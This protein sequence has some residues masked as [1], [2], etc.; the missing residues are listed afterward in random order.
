M[1][2]VKYARVLLTKKSWIMTPNGSS[3]HD[4]CIDKAAWKIFAFD[5]PTVIDIKGVIRGEGNWTLR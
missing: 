1:I 2:K 5:K 4:S 3:Q